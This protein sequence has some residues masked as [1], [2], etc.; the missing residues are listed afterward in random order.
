M[1]TITPF[2]TVE[3]N[4]WL[5]VFHR[6]T[7]IRWLK[8]LAMGEFVHVSALAYCAGFKAWLVYDTQLNGTRLFLIPHGDAVKSFFVEHA[9]GAEIVRF[10][11]QYGGMGFTSR[12]GF[13]CVPAI[14]HLLAVRCG[15]WRP[16]ALYRE[17]IRL[18]G[19]R[20]NE[21]KHSANPADRAGSL[22]PAGTGAGAE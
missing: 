6:K 9:D 13:Y 1:D 20:V 19:T 2:S 7:K 5:V 12:L 11:R 10:R 4:D 17:L 22:V 18:G 8:W 3:P 21:R 15:A 14:K 16:D